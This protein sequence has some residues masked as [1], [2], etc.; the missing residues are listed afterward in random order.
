M[1]CLTGPVVVIRGVLVQRGRTG[2]RVLPAYRGRRGSQDMT[3]VCLS[4]ITGHRMRDVR[5]AV[6]NRRAR[7]VVGKLEKG[8]D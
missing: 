3:F 7:R 1:V 5:T 6:D 2:A 8:A 4:G